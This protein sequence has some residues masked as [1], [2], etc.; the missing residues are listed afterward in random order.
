MFLLYKEGFRIV[1]HTSNI[2]ESDWAQ[3]TQG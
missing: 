3:K 1:I 2:V